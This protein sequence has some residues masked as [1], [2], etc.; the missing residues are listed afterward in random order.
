M[1]TSPSTSVL[2]RRLAAAVVLPGLLTSSLVLIQPAAAAGTTSNSSICNGVVNQLAH[3]G[4]VQENLLKA[5]SKRNADAIAALQ[6]EKE[7]LQGQADVVSG[8]M[9]AVQEAL[10]GLAA[11]EEQ[12]DKDIAST[13]SELARVEAEAKLKSTAIV[14][15][16]A[17]LVRLDGQQLDVA[18]E[19]APLEE[20]LDAAVAALDVL[21][22]E[23]D[24]LITARDTNDAAIA[25]AQGQRE[26]L[27]QAAVDAA[28]AVAGQ[29][30]QIVL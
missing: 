10:D 7:K 20:E 26:A 27:Q 12:L 5:A 21:K 11:Q 18:S 22:V 19:L 2:S 24:K 29:E 13:K 8:D 14:E 23:A 4:T 6:A 17:E 30:A 9:A 3:R 15:A 1:R 16:K 28:S 25:V